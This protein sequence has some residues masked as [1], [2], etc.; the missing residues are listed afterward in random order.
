MQVA[1]DF[2]KAPHRILQMLL[3][4]GEGGAATPGPK[5]GKLGQ[6]LLHLGT[7]LA[8]VEAGALLPERRV[9]LLPALLPSGDFSFVDL[10]GA[11]V[12][13]AVEESH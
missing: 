9:P 13:V 4:R 5:L 11:D 8:L 1:H 3:Q 2:P 6:P 12:G 10:R 7:D